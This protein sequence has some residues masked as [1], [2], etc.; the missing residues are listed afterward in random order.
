VAEGQYVVDPHAVAEAMLRRARLNEA[1][2]FS[3]MLKAAKVERFPAGV[4][5]A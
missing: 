3:S 4:D 5:Q 1:Q 2:R